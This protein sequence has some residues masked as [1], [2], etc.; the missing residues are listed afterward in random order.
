MS[1]FEQTRTLAFLVVAIE[2][3]VK[4]EAKKHSKVISAGNRKL[5]FYFLMQLLCTTAVT[6]TELR[7]V[8]STIV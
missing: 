8:S 7:E 5:V 2:S 3:M 1:T 4:E 6:M